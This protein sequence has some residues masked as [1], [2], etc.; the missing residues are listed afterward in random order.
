MYNDKYDYGSIKKH[1]DIINSIFKKE[2]HLDNITKEKYKKIESSRKDILLFTKDNIKNIDKKWAE[3]LEP[4]FN[5]IRYIN[6]HSTNNYTIFLTY[7]RKIYISLSK[8]NN[9][10]DFII[11][12]HEYLHILT[13]LLNEKSIDTIE[14]ET[15]SILGELIT[16]Y[17]MRKAHLFTSETNKA[18]INNFYII[19][20]QLK[21]YPARLDVINN[22]ISYKSIPKYLTTNYNVKKTDIKLIYDYSLDYMYS[23][24]ISYFLAIELFEIYKQDKEKCIH[25]CNQI[26]K[27]NKEFTQKLKDNNIEITKNS[28]EYIKKLKKEYFSQ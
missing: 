2:Y 20:Q 12:T 21:A 1:T 19:D 8:S 5:D 25:I 13:F 18:D 7:L 15:I 11:P 24:I 6:F 17:E 4:Y 16:T 9:I 27:S 28:D 3:L 23:T 14:R 22:D 26:I 10:E